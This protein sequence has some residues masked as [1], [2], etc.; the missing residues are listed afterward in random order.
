MSP[1]TI[2]ATYL[3]FRTLTKSRSHRVEYSAKARNSLPEVISP[4]FW[5]AADY[6]P[7][8]GER[9]MF[10]PTC[11]ATYLTFRTLTKS[12]SHRVEY[13]GKALNSLMVLISPK[14]WAAADYIPSAGGRLTS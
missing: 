14:F 5:A 11:G 3:T 4:R 13:S 6:I 7:S 9:W 2:G 12:R 8:A 1:P 10:S